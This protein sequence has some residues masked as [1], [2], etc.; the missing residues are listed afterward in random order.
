MRLN[1]EQEAA[2]TAPDGP[3]MVIAGPG[4]G[5]TFVITRRLDHMISV[6][7]ILPEN[8]LVVTFTRAAADEMKDRFTK[9]AGRKLPV[10]FGTFHSVFF[11]ILKYAYGYSAKDIIAPDIRRKKIREELV[12]A[13][14]SVKGDEDAVTHVSDEIAYIKENGQDPDLFYSNVCPENIFRTVYKGYE[15]YLRASGLLDFEDMVKLVYELFKV[16]PDILA[17]WQRKYTHILVD[18]FQDINPMQ[19]DIVKLLA[20]DGNLFVVG[21]D[22]QSIYRFRGAR[23]EIMLGFGKDFKDAKILKLSV[24]YRS[25]PDVVE[26]S[27]RLIGKNRKRY[28]KNL[29]AFE[30]THIPV[31]VWEFSDFSREN[32]HIANMIAAMA[33]NGIPYEDI[34]VLY[35]TN[36]GPRGIVEKLNRLNIPFNLSDLIPDVYSHWIAQDIITY[37]MIGA[38][39]R[40]RGDFLRIINRPVRYLKRE[41]FSDPEIDLDSVIGELADKEWLAE[42][43]DQLAHDI[44]VISGLSP[45]EA[46]RYIRK[47]VGYDSFLREYAADNGI[48][49][50]S[51]MAVLDDVMESASSCKT[52]KE[53]M[54]RIREEREIREKGRQ[55]HGM[56]AG[57]SIMTMHRAKG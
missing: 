11:N 36:T 7:G 32:Q 35:R 47:F 12:R 18:E 55:E 39:S 43:V 53:W 30:K 28:A 44:Y 57:V 6:R 15:E 3:V 1:K 13:G 37:L 20:A 4:S 38:G 33:K 5:K 19:Y 2:V 45:Y 22:D 24:N 25:V 48:S 27:V 21:D 26:T 31:K 52:L 46:I 8:I 14:Y 51:L 40:R 10:T 50:D 42:R 54:E 9:M 17:G 56:A 23:P 29:E 16:R 34:A 41:L 49:E